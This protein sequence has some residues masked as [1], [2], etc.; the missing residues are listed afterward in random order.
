[1][2]TITFKVKE[3]TEKITASCQVKNGKLVTGEETAIARMI[4]ETITEAIKSK[5]ILDLEVS[6]ESN[7]PA[8]SPRV[9]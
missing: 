3:T 5:T 2:I 4:Y 1:M 9:Y 6:N 8:R 7:I